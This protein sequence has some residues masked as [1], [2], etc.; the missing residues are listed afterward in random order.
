M[1]TTRSHEIFCETI[2]VMLRDR[3]MSQSDLSRSLGVS[4]AYVSQILSGRNV[5]S[6]D[7]LDRLAAA[8]DC[9]PHELLQPMQEKIPA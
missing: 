7:L 4:R 3:R 5:P 6:L 1:I 2:Q 9:E 8:L